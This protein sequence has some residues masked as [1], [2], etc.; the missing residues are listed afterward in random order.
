MRKR[1]NRD[2]QPEAAPAEIEQ[3]EGATQSEK[4]LNAGE[5]AKDLLERAAVC[6][7][8][9]ELEGT[10]KRLWKEAERAVIAS[11]RVA[12]RV[13]KQ[14]SKAEREAARKAKKAEKI[15]KLRERLKKLLEEEEGT[16]D[17]RE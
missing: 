17:T 13:E 16:G 8:V 5:Q 3:F 6:F 11:Q 2:G 1:T 12:K 15:R 14:G 9:L 7:R 4:V 10:A